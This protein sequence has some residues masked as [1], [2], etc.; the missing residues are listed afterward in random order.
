MIKALLLILDPAGTWDRIALT[1]RSWPVILCFY[2][3]PLLVIGAAAEGYGMVH[4]GKPRGEIM[5]LQTF[6]RSTAL[7]F[8]LLQMLMMLGIVFVGARLIKA[9]G[10]TFHGR[11]S[12][13]QG[14][15]VAAYG[16][17]PIF[18]VRIFD[19]LPGVSSWIY[20]A[21]W[22][23]GVFLSVATLYHGIPRVMKPDPPHAFGLYITS[24]VLLTFISGLE[25]F[26]AFWYLQGRIGN[27]D[28]LIAKLIAHVP[29]LQ[30]LDRKHF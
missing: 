10:E 19:M 24:S 14:F 4:W 1:K 27:L 7:V 16:M 21:V 28:I 15:T 22:L 11:H 9:M 12:F 13:E 25:R 5:Q 18:A 8:E 29:L 2:L 20:W 17:A 23:G 26:I 6:S 3:I 30:S